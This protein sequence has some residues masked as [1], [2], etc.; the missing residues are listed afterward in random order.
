[1]PKC[2]HADIIAIYHELL[3]TA[4]RMQIRTKARDSLMQARWREVCAEGKLSKEEG[5][6]AFRVFFGRQVAQSKFLTGRAQPRRPDERP[7]KA[8]LEWLM[9]PTNFVKVL[10]G[11][12][13]DD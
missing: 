1:M 9:R 6:N 8:D 13:S 7:F 2:P 3:P 12:Y 5:L 11:K 10:E 4:P